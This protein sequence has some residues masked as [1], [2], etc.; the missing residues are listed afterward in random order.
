MHHKMLPL[1][2]VVFAIT[3]LLGAFDVISQWAVSIAWPIV[4]GVAGLSKLM[5]GSCKCC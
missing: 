2:V 3:F 1:L 4:V 5:E